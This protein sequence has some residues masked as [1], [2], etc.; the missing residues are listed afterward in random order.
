[1][2]K[3]RELEKQMDDTLPREPRKS[4]ASSSGVSLQLLRTKNILISFRIINF[5]LKT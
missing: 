1:M 2:W 5:C 3:I 4:I